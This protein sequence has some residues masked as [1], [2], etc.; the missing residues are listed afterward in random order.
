MAARWATPGRTYLRIAGT[1]A[2]EWWHALL[3]IALTAGQVSTWTGQVAG[4]VLPAPGA[5]QRPNYAADGTAFAGATMVQSVAAT[6]QI[7]RAFNT[8][9][10]VLA[11]A[12]ALPCVYIRARLRT[13]AANVRVAD[14]YDGGSN[15]RAMSHLTALGTS[16]LSFSNTTTVTV[17]SAVAN[18]AVHNWTGW[19]DGV[20]IH[21]QVDGVATAAADAFPIDGNVDS[22]TLGAFGL[23]GTGTPSDSTY[24]VIVWLSTY[25]AAVVADLE[26]L[27][28]AELPP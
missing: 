16:A 7:L 5:A 18:T 15:L 9:V 4:R 27:G 12:G 19:I 1:L 10:P 24:G 11:A 13:L 2:T 28:A 14:S 25:N 23:N 17:S 20:Q 6:L 26:R 3:G 8:L 21:V 22:Y